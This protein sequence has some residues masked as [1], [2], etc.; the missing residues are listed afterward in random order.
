[1]PPFLVF[2]LACQAVSTP[3]AHGTFDPKSVLEAG[4]Y[5]ALESYYAA[6]QE[7][8][9]A[10]AIS[11]SDLAW[12]YEPLNAR[13]GMQT[14]SFDQWVGRYPNSYYSHL[15]RGIYEQQI[16]LFM[17]GGEF[18]SDTPPSQMREM[19]KFLE[20]ARKDLKLSLR[21]DSRPFLSLSHLINIA[22]TEGDD[23]S[24]ND[25]LALG[26]RLFPHNRQIRFAYFWHLLPRWGGS[27]PQ[28][29]AFIDRFKT[30]PAEK[31][32]VSELRAIE[33][34]D[35]GSVAW[36]D[37]DQK[38]AKQHFVRAV[39]LAKQAHR[40]FPTDYLCSA[41]V[42]L[43]QGLPKA[44]PSAASTKRFHAIGGELAQA[45]AGHR[46]D[47]AKSLADEYLKLA[48]SNNLD[49]ISDDAAHDAYLALGL[50]ALSRGDRTEALANLNRARNAHV[51]HDR[52]AVAPSFELANKLIAL[53]YR[54]E[55]IDYLSGVQQFWRDDD[56]LI[57][58]WIRDIHAGKR[59]DLQA[60]V[61][62]HSNR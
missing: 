25:Y 27:Y 8:F 24:A 10:D 26:D 55:V 17:R 58:K 50:V 62:Q 1:M 37:G 54:A 33:E 4:R 45:L 28:M 47:Q 11:E 53:G 12:A 30:N 29:E 15:A 35:K 43:N 61:G 40:S 6:E 49:P 34:E 56:G 18:A 2:M 48:H 41:H 16:G 60:E 7:K 5:D 23:E 19:E 52:S 38:I 36:S 32:F 21:L 39:A 59:P 13:S 42:F 22:N 20:L 14:S 57:D 44:P 51:P 9:K 3:P 31:D 46:Y